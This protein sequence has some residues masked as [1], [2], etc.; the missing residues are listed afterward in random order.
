MCPMGWVSAG[1]AA[2]SAGEGIAAN[3]SAQSATK[4]NNAAA[5]TTRAANDSMLNQAETVAQ[6][7][8]QAYTGTLTAPMSGNQQQGYS[9]A[10]STANGG[11]AQADNTAATGLIGQVANNGWNSA[12]AANYMNPYT[13]DVTNASTA[14]LN[15]SYLQNLSGLQTNSAGS[16]A[17]GGSRQA[18]QEATLASNNNINVGSLT[19][20]NNANAYDSAMKAWSADNN[21]KIS[22]A[23][24]YNQSGQDLTQMTS[25]Q[26]SDLIKTGGAAQ[27]ISQTNLSNEYNQFMRQQNWSANQLGSLIT[28]VGASKGSSVQ[29]PA[30]QSNTANQLLGLGS[31]VAGLFGG[32]GGSQSIGQT[33]AALNASSQNTINTNYNSNFDNNATYGAGGNLTLPAY[34]GNST[35]LTTPPPS[36]EGG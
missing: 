20:T 5:A 35:A 8:F 29:T 12:T 19:A 33:D 9:L 3:Q 14:A 24:A 28:A 15:K 21:T 4:A 30:V 27:A 22:A 13:Q 23:N 16:G 32:S 25:Q 17:F 36:I 11:A 18:I 7:P 26:I 34:S 2:I 10:S 31:T 6:Q 1:A